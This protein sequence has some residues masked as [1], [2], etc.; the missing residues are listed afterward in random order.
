MTVQFTETRG[1]QRELA[2]Q[3]SGLAAR[4]A[5]TG[6]RYGN[7]PA[8]EKQLQF[9]AKLRKERVVTDE[10]THDIEFELQQPAGPSKRLVS[11]FIDDLLKLPFTGAS[12]AKSGPRQPALPEVPAGRYAIT[13]AE[14]NEGDTASHGTVKFYRV[15]RPTDG[16]WAG[17]TFV[18]VQAGDDLYP[19]KGAARAAV[20][21]AILDAGPKEASVRYG[22]E[23][24]HCGV[25]GRT[26]TDAD[27]R[28]AGIGPVCAA[29]AGW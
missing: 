9:L 25:C 29:N 2:Q 27:S 17:W 15:D 22:H 5:Y 13:V 4:A 24:G 11:E 18:K 26:L 6:P 7:P 1:F 28:A 20:L 23:L 10:L 14:P 21:Q 16:A 19:V 12:Q 3:R 8:T